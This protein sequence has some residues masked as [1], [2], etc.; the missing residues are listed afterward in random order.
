MRSCR[1]QN[2]NLLT[3]YLA[4]DWSA[5]LAKLVK[6][7]RPAR[8]SASRPSEIMRPSTQLEVDVEY[9]FSSGIS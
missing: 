2:L 1:L 6:P 8:H 5:F 9:G 3:Q 7:A 4:A